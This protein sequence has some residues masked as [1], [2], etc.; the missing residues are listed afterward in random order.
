MQ[1]KNFNVIN[2]NV[3]NYNIGLSK[4]TCHFD[5]FFQKMFFIHMKE[6]VE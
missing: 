4:K 2:Y 6:L 1:I 5:F 3:K